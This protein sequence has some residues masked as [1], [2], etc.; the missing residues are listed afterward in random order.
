MTV[1]SDTKDEFY[2]NLAAIIS[3]VPNSEQLVLLGDFN[4][5]VG[6]D[7]DTWPSCLGQFGVGKM[8]ENG[9]RL[10]ELCT[11][12]DLCI[13]NS[14]FRTKPQHKVSWR[15]PR[16]KHWHQ[17]D[18]ILF[19]RAALKNVLH[20]RSYH[21]ADCNTDHSLVCCKIR[22]QP[23]RFHR[24]KKQ[25][26]PRIYVS[27]MSQPNL[28]SQFAEAFE[29][30]FGAPQPKDSATEKWEI[31]RDTMHRTA[32]ATF[33]EKSSRTHDWFDAK[34][35]EMTPVIEAKR[36]ALIEYKRSPSERN[37]QILIA[38]RSKVQQTARR[39]AN[40]YWTQLS[41]DIQTAA[42]TENI[43]GMHDGIKKA[44]GPTQSKTAPL[45]SSNHRQ[46]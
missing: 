5:R 36:T 13:A 1:T 14:Y 17:L 42:I 9:Q 27:K 35:S 46:S 23:K 34:S 22:L 20:T 37:L 2:E 24:T 4:A 21:S 41:E 7:H 15:H 28:M 29:R 44:L 6:A 26:N 11:Y 8:D 30:E 40:E 19:R 18:L 25:G 33:G 45:K 12:D 32:L 10:L 31:L 39:C 3:S 38:A 16:S 43:K